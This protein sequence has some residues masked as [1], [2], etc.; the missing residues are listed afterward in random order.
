MFCKN[1]KYKNWKETQESDFDRKSK[2]RAIPRFVT[3]SSSLISEKQNSHSQHNSST[4]RFKW[5][6][7]K[8]AATAR[9][10]RSTLTMTERDKVRDGPSLGKQAATGTRGSSVLPTAII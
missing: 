6:C 3:K 5:M 8:R 2:N 9:K 10:E 1:N 4:R 7:N